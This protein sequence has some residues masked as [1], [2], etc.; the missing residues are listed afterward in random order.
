MKIWIGNPSSIQYDSMEKYSPNIPEPKSML[1]INKQHQNNC[2]LNI[3]HHHLPS[4]KDP[5]VNKNKSK[6]IIKV[7]MVTSRMHHL[8]NH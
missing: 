8:I 1:P 2:P 5:E 6:I 7:I 4:A 3:S